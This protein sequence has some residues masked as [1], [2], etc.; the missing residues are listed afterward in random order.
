[1]W[2]KIEAKWQI[3]SAEATHSKVAQFHATPC[4]RCIRLVL[5]SRSLG[6]LQFFKETL[7]FS[8]VARTVNVREPANPFSSPGVSLEEAVGPGQAIIG[9]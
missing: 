6:S 1:M 5:V 8:A 9:K 7:G 3:G 4:V 2:W